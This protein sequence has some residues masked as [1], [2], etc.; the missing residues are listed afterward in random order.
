MQHQQTVA[1]VSVFYSYAHEDEPLRRATGEASQL[2]RRQGLISEWH[3]RESLPG[4]EWSREID[5]HLETA[6][7]ILLL[8]SPRLP[9]L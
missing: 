1:P 6:S 3:D 5:E 7:I 4:T 9:G 8:I 2:L